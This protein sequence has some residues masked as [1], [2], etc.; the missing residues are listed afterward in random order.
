MGGV[1]EVDFYFN[2]IFT[3]RQTL[4]SSSSP[5]KTDGNFFYYY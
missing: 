2:F 5:V 3:K 4:T 1:E